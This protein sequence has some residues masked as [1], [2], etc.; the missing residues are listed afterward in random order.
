MRMIFL[1]S[2]AQK[3]VVNISPPGVDDAQAV[4][5]VDGAQARRI[6]TILQACKEGWE[7]LHD[8]SRVLVVLLWLAL[9]RPRF[10]FD[11]VTPTAAPQHVERGFRGSDKRQLQRN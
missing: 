9:L 1:A 6:R 4:P 10:H 11:R 3:S 8:D 7:A 5:G 2:S